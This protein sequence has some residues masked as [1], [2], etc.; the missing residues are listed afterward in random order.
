MSVDFNKYMLCLIV[1]DRGLY[2][3]TVCSALVILYILILNCKHFLIS[4]F[5]LLMYSG[6]VKYVL[7]LVL[8]FLVKQKEVFKLFHTEFL[9]YWKYTVLCVCVCRGECM[10]AFVYTFTNLYIQC[11]VYM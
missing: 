10:Y 11:S 3:Y 8:H 6:N 9:L 7:F 2:V 1:N 5:L 4:C